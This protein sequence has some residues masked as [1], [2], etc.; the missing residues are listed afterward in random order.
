MRHNIL[1]DHDQAL[2]KISRRLFQE[3]IKKVYYRCNRNLDDPFQK[4]WYMRQDRRRFLTPSTPCRCEHLF[5]PADD[6]AFQA[7]LDPMR[8]SRRI[9]ENIFNDTFSQFP[10]TLVLLH[11]DAYLRSLVNIFPPGSIHT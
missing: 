11:D 4:K 2:D 10:G 5:D 7:Y 3:T 6:A 9:G 1:P 8:M